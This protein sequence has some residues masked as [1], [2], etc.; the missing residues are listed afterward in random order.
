MPDNKNSYAE[1][2]FHRLTQLG[3]LLN[4]K[5][6]LNSTVN[7]PQWFDSDG[8][9]P[10]RQKV[11]DHIQT[12]WRAETPGVVRGKKAIILS[13]PP[14]AGKGTILKQILAEM[15]SNPDQWRIIDADIFKDKLLQQAIA[16]GS[17]DSFIKPQ[18]I[19]DLEAQ[20]E[21]FFPRE[22]ASLVHEES[23]ILAE[24]ARLRAIA[25][26]ENIVFDTVLSSPQSAAELGRLLHES[27]YD[28]HVV[29]IEVPHEVSAASA[30]QRWRDGY[31]KALDG[32][33]P[34]GGRIVPED[35]IHHIFDTSD[36]HSR[37]YTTA[38]S[39]AYSCPAVS[40]F[41][42]YQRDAGNNGFTHTNRRIRTAPGTP[43]GPPH[44]Q[45]T[46]PPLNPNPPTQHQWPQP[47]TALPRHR[48]NNIHSHFNLRGR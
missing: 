41:D 6:S 21:Q 36:G 18:A 9:T 46:G 44:H 3:P 34:L 24:Q 30:K 31:F 20:G 19:K 2:H 45:P 28:V 22:L 32:D 48:T 5:T 23:S 40:Q 14:G 8:T 39:L 33:N 42:Q 43:L 16:D 38:R 11:H 29:N 10:N 4:S 1:I 15:G 47:T 7:N 25:S 17:Y 26:G 13:G 37:P 12:E 27:G 35:Y